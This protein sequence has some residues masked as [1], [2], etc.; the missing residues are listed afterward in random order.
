MRCQPRSHQQGSVHRFHVNERA[1][2]DVMP[3]IAT[4]RARSIPRTRRAS[5]GGP[6]EGWD[7]AVRWARSM[8]T[9]TPRR[10]WWATGTIGLLR[11]ATRPASS[12]IFAL[13]SSRSCRGGGYF[14]IFNQS[15]PRPCSDWLR[16]PGD[17]ADR[18]SRDRH[19]RFEGT[20]HINRSSLF[21]RTDEVEIDH[22]EQAL[23]R[24]ST[25]A[26]RSAAG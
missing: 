25:S 16:R 14:K 12:R 9:A 24:C 21:R 3:C 17:R 26:S 20:P 22:I 7:R 23:P 10:R 13:A 2:L 18:P 6:I 19:R 11:T 15:V 1:M 5:C 8:D 4:P